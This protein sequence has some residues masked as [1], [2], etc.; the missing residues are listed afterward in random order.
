MKALTQQQFIQKARGIH[1][2]KYDYSNSLYTGMFNK[3]CI[4]CSKHGNFYQTPNAHIYLK[5]GCVKCSPWSQ[6]LTYTEFIKR[7][8]KI[9]KNKY[10]YSMIDKKIFKTCNT[11]NT[12][13]PVI[14]KL[15]GMWMP[16]IQN[17][18][19]GSGCKRCGYEYNG[20]IK[21]NSYLEV[22]NKCNNIHNKTYQYP[23][24]QT[25]YKGLDSKITIVCKKH[26]EFKQTVRNHILG[27]PSRC[28]QCSESRGESY[29]KKWLSQHSIE[30]VP[31]HS[32]DTC[33]NHITNRLLKFDVFVPLYNM[34][35]EFDG[36]HHFKT[37]IGA[38][39]NNH[40]LTHEEW[41]KIKNRDTIKN[42]F[43]KR[44]NYKLIRIPYTKI[45]QIDNILRKTTSIESK[46]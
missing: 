38:M 27:L 10:D 15:H 44:N 7:S 34:C 42:N 11:N 45:D 16:N 32:F 31:Q 17:H 46:L 2:N 8:C 26:G 23:H 18:M 6:K 41:K 36:P 28:P 24:I 5:T 19:T 21:R 25:E 20:Q 43:C 39:Y 40:K 4:I 33:R 30:H 3:V 35:I 14:C 22:L 13:V 37:A 12:K 9:H 1:K 29:I